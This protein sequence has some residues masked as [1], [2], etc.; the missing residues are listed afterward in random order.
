MCYSYSRLVTRGHTS[1]PVFT[2]CYSCLYPIV[3]GCLFHVVTLCNAWS[4]IVIHIVSCPL[5]LNTLNLV[6]DSSHI[7]TLC[8]GWSRFVTLRHPL[9]WLFVPGRTWLRFPRCDQLL[10]LVTLCHAWSRVYTNGQVCPLFLTIVIM[11]IFFTHSHT[12]LVALCHAYSL[13]VISPS[14]R[15]LPTQENTTYKHKRQTSRDSNP[16]SQQPRDCWPTS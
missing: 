14:Q 9:L 16:R 5:F 10:R 3:L 12:R 6:R 8:H 2:P 13:R 15:P 4:L 11:F 1:A 7:V